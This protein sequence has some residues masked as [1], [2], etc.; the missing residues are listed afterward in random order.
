MVR[1]GARKTRSLLIIHKMKRIFPLKRKF[2]RVKV[3]YIISIDYCRCFVSCNVNLNK[4]SILKV[5]S[6]N[7]NLNKKSILKVNSTNKYVFIRMIITWCDSNAKSFNHLVGEFIMSDEDIKD[8]VGIY[9][10]LN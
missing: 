9:Q 7:V 5:N 3:R 4:K 1:K 6:C 2:M 10:S 8:Y